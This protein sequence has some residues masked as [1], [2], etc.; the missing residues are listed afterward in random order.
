MSDTTPGAEPTPE[1]TPPPSSST[2]PPASSGGGW[3]GSAA[4]QQANEAVATLKKGNPLDLATIGAG[5]LVL[6]GSLL[7]YYTVSVS[8]FGANASESVT[9]WHGFFGWFG[10]LLALAAAVVLVLHLLAVAL[11]VPVRLTVLGLLALSALCTLLALFVMPGGSCDDSLLG[12][13]L[14]DMID[15]GHGVG[16][17]LALLASLAGT[18]LAVLRRTAP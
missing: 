11:P 12:G 5:L 1:P 16:Y 15:Q 2:P 14:C 17:W 4:S 6:L 10:A 3:S 8:G 18:G 7:P 13:S 9:A